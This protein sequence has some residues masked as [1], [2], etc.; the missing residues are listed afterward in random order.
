MLSS[1]DDFIRVHELLQSIHNVPN[2]PTGPS[3]IA[4]SRYDVR[5]VRLDDELLLLAELLLKE[6]SFSTFEL[7]QFELRFRRAVAAQPANRSSRDLNPNYYSISTDYV[8]KG[9]K[10]QLR[11]GGKFPRRK[12][13]R[14]QPRKAAIFSI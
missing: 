2:E 10:L 12:N 11:E 4:T 9:I 5:N 14:F 13:P 7:R 8:S 6:D 3:S 1:W